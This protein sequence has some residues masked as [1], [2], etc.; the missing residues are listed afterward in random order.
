VSGSYVHVVALLLG[1]A[2]Y[3]SMSP[4]AAPRRLRRVMPLDVVEVRTSDVPGRPRIRSVSAG[5]WACAG[6]G[7]ALALLLPPIVGLVMGVAIA[8][9]GPV[10]LAR[11]EPRHV[12]V[13]RARV[14]RDLALM[15]DLFAACL[16]G[17]APVAVAARSVAHALSGP[18]ADDL[19]AVAVR[20]DLG[21]DPSEVWRGFGSDDRTRRIGLALAR[22]S[23]TG[24]ATSSALSAMAADQR[25]SVRREGEA[26]ARRVAV[27]VA[28]PLGLCFLPAFVLLGI[29]PAVLGALAPVLTR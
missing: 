20:L 25:S 11:L 23:L 28:A 8:L 3:A 21:A 26:A 29:V 2:T 1:A 14:Q 17:G 4:P 19:Q 5:R 18:L 16:S 7:V 12:R 27:R 9:L 24:S 10:A 6:A 15:L 13:R 22:A